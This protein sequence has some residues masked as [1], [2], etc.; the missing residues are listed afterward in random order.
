MALKMICWLEFDISFSI[1][2]PN[3]LIVF[4]LIKLLNKKEIRLETQTD[5]SETPV[6]YE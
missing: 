3:E 1:V 4:I 6:L 2:Q 5:K